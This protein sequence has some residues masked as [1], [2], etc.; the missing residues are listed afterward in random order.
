[1]S[2][3]DTNDGERYRTL[4]AGQPIVAQHAF[5]APR[6]CVTDIQWK[7]DVLRASIDKASELDMAEEDTLIADECERLGIVFDGL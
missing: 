2:P 5:S 3:N 7:H 1:M 6:R 4:F